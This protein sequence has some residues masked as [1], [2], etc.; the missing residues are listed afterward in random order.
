VKSLER[1]IA[2]LDE[3][4]SQ[5]QRDL[6]QQILDQSKSLDD[7]LQHNHEELLAALERESKE[8]HTSKTDR[9]TLAR[10]FS[11][12]ALLLDNESGNY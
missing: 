7:A 6:R 8:L 11:E 9:S 12:L 2:Q 4:T 1:K 10:L 3:Q 5:T